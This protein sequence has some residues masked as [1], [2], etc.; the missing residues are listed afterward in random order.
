MMECRHCH[1]NCTFSVVISD[2]IIIGM[3]W[4]KEIIFRSWYVNNDIQVLELTILNDIKK[5]DIFGMLT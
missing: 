3:A 1:Y 2:M 5:M 4:W